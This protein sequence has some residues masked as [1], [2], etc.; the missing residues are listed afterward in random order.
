VE[1]SASIKVTSA[2]LGT[3][4]SV[5][6]PLSKENVRL[7]LYLKTLDPTYTYKKRKKSIYQ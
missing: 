6:C 4:S 5:L 7:G 3:P 2:T 1:L